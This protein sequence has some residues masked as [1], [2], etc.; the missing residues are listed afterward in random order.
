MKLTDE[1][2]AACQ[3]CG[4]EPNELIVKYITIIDLLF[5]R[6]TQN[7]TKAEEKKRL[8]KI[9]IVGNFVQEKLK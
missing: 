1:A 5:F 7:E 6:D 3:M 4:V 8:T 9:C 2:L